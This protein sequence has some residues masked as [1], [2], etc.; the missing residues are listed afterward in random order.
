[1]KIARGKKEPSIYESVNEQTKGVK[2]YS[3]LVLRPGKER[4]HLLRSVE[5]V[6]SDRKKVVV[7]S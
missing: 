4:L 6:C 1:M 7:E 5:V 2:L 3:R